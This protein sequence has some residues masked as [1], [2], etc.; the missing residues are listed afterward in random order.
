MKT[1]AA[2]LIV[3]ACHHDPQPTAPTRAPSPF[4]DLEAK[5]QPVFAAITTIEP[6]VN[7]RDCAKLATQLRQF[8]ADHAAELGD[9]AK[10]RDQL[11]PDE[12]DELETAHGADLARMDRTIA[13]AQHACP[14]DQ[15][16][17][18][19]LDVSGFKRAPATD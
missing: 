14:G 16:V 10:L 18:A 11:G 12:R 15:A 8:G 3:A 17:D 5:L 1:L 2:I 9:A 4:S 6:T 13:G 19:A 7:A